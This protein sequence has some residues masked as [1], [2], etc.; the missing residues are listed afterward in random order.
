[1]AMPKRGQPR[2]PNTHRHDSCRLGSLLP[3]TVNFK[4]ERR[5][6]NTEIEMIAY[7]V[8]SGAPAGDLDAVPPAPK[9][10]DDWALGEPDW[11]A[12]MPVEYEI[13]PEGEDEY[14]QFIIP[15]N[16]RDRHVRSSR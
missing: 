4:N 6:T 10:H 9:F 8:E 11:I 12:E 1:M 15:T 5:L 14:R 13:E 2:S 7:W 16:F 3:A